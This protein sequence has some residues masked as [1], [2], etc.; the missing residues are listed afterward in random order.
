MGVSCSWTLVIQFARNRKKNN[1][2]KANIIRSQFKE[3][4]MSGKINKNIEQ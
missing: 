4:E 3:A 2:G 1:K